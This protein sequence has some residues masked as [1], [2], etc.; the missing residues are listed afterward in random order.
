MDTTRVAA[1][2]A[3]FLA[4]PLSQSQLD[5]ISIYIDLLLRWNARM[6]LT[7]IR[8]E[9]EIVTRH[10][11]ESLFLAGHVLRDNSAESELTRGLVGVRSQL[12][13]GEPFRATDIGSGAGFPAIPLKIWSPDIEITLIESNHKKATF[14]REV[15]RALALKG[16]AV[17]TERAEALAADPAFPRTQLVTL[18]AVE[19]FE[20]VLPLAEALLAPDG[21]LALLIGSAQLPALR[22][23]TRLGWKEPT[24]VPHSQTRVLSIGIQQL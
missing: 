17:R 3:P 13:L 4:K 11:G 8:D 1:L 23:L 14:L 15:V 9:E 2:L 21:T 5:P 6:N 18:R 19:H 10:F 7:A 16:V 22:R 20:A 12:R 24:P